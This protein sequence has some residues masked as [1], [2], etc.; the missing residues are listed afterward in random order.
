MTWRWITRLLHRGKH[1]HGNGSAARAAREAAE[2]K[3]AQAQRLW[4]KTEEAHDR[5]AELIENALRGNR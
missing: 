5:L 3:R 2:R 4:P 1:V